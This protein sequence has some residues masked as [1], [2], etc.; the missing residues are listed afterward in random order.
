MSDHSI[1]LRVSG[2]YIH[3]ITQGLLPRALNAHP[4]PMCNVE[5][6][7]VVPSVTSVHVTHPLRWQSW[8]LVWLTS[9][10]L[11]MARSCRRLRSQKSVD[12]VQYDVPYQY[13]S[14][15]FHMPGVLPMLCLVSYLMCSLVSSWCQPRTQRVAS[16]VLSRFAPGMCSLASGV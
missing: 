15:I 10:C 16:G 4:L 1:Y 8:M 6:S 11:L 9:H 2:V 3:E 5:G 14:A 13:A 12:H 7:S